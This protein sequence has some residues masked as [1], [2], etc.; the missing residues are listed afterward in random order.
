MPDPTQLEYLPL[1]SLAPYAR[2]A[3]T[4]SPAQITQLVA[5]IKEFGFTNPVLIDAQGGII[6]GHGRVLAAQQVGMVTVP[7]LRLGHL[8]ETQKRAYIIADNKLALNAG[9]DMDLLAQELAAL[10]LE[11]FELDLL[12]FDEESLQELLGETTPK[13]GLSHPDASPEAPV[14]PVS[15]PGDLWLLGKHRLLC[16]D[17]T[18]ADDVARVL[19]TDQP[20]LMVTDPPYGD[21]YDADWRNRRLRA[22]G[23]AIGGRAIDK[24][25]N[26]GKADWSDAWELFAKH[27]GGVAYVWHAQ[28]HCPTVADSLYA[29]GFEIRNLIIWA[30]SSLVISR[31]NY[32]NQHEPCWYVVKKGINARF[33]EDRTQTTIFKDIQDVVRPGELVFLAKDA[34]KKV[35]A[36]RADRSC[37]WQ[38]P[39]PSKSETGHSTQKPVECMARPMRNHDSEMIYEPFSGSGT[40]IIAAEQNGR[41]CLAVELNPAYVDVAV[42]RWQTFT[43]QTARHAVTG[44]PFPG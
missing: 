15:K 28:T 33:T 22:D 17:S 14:T 18:K 8:T 29:T 42:K 44:R 24:V 30:K 7:C 31:G 37:L 6:A 23:S 34:A 9:W 25:S 20:F 35:Y 10:R 27:G 38:I 36:I 13:Q 16:G 39:K 4:H 41:R 1:A 43:G 12:G 3:R 40:T 5:S 11:D 2:N 26:D 21:N 19:G 32:H